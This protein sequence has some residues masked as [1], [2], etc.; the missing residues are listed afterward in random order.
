MLQ[1]LFKRAQAT[2]DSAIS[3]VLNRVLLAIPF[4]IAAGFAMA[5]TWTELHERLGA[6]GA[7][8]SIAGA[9]AILGL[10]MAPFLFGKSSAPGTSEQAEEQAA[11]PEAAARSEEP[12]IPGLGAIGEVDGELIRSMV[13]AIGPSALPYVLRR[14]A[15]NLPL[16]ILAAAAIFVMLQLSSR[17]SR[18][19]ETEGEPEPVM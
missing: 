15:R 16:A 6:T 7:N 18:T 4:V 3:D 1:A 10:I 9:F 17:P 13:S 11:T 14:L 8:L 12:A 5:A 19:G 2:V